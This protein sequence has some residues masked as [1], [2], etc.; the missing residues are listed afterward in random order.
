MTTN[1]LIRKGLLTTVIILLLIIIIQFAFTWYLI[2]Q[3]KT[4]LEKEVDVQS[5]GTYA[6]SIKKLNINVFTQSIYI[7]GFNL[8][9]GKNST[10]QTTNL[11]MNAD[12]IKLIR[13]ELIPLFSKNKL[14][15]NK[16]EVVNPSAKIFRNTSG[17]YTAKPDT[18]L[19]ISLYDILKKHINSL[20]IK[21]ISIY[22]A[23]IEVYDN[24]GDSLP[25]IGSKENEL[26][27]VNFYV[28]S[29]SNQSGRLFAADKLDLMIRKF[30]YRTADSLYSIQVKQLSASY[31]EQELVLDSLQVTP[32]YTRRNFANEAGKQ[33]D[34]FRMEASK[35]KFE[36]MNV[37]MFLERN[38][39][40]AN[41]LSI[42]NVNISAYRD[43]NDRRKEVRVPSVQ[44]LIR[45][46]PFYTAIDTIK[47]SNAAVVYEEVIEGASKAGKV[48][49]NDMNASITGL[50]SDT[51]LFKNQ[52]LIVNAK[53]KFMNKGLVKA[54]YKFPL[55]TTQT[56]FDCS[57][58]MI[59]IP[60]TALNPM[61]E[62]NANISLK[63]GVIDS[64]LFSFHANER[65][66]TGEMKLIYHGLKIELI[67]KRTKK[68]GRLEDVISFVAHRLV[69]K[70][71][72][73]GKN[74][75]IRITPISYIRN[76]NRFIFN[77]S[78]KA[79]LSG[80]RPVIGI[81]SAKG[82]NN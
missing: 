24:K 57:G 20:S 51:N 11:T 44:Q 23:A 65:M 28:N 29:A 56:I 7:K 52:S 77:Y 70:E 50:T 2:P 74:G 81:P 36:K 34:R 17:Y 32:N 58:K 12:Q 4:E 22:D 40:I 63:E 13:F 21:K 42:E 54:R 80:I 55:N 45:S 48:F 47:I 14:I 79:L 39:F 60:M 73:P 82:E 5:K 26:S 18:S 27:V 71:D 67:N 19:K 1:K 43:K 38:W 16:M 9:P 49:L 69:I 64:M 46:I 25:T 78:W 41:L 31:N 68:S 61:V 59:N 37:K 35:V 53:G 10:E 15:V 30:S 66:A 75:E 76:P 3:I 6:L 33:T 72:N 62:T 8:T